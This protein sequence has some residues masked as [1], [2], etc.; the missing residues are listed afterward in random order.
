[1]TSQNFGKMIL[2][3]HKIIALFVCIFCVQV[4]D[5]QEVKVLT[6]ETFLTE[7]VNRNPE[8]LRADLDRQAVRLEAEIFAANLK[9]QLTG[10]ANFPNYARTFQEVVQPDGTIAF[11]SVRNNNSSVSL[12]ATQR[13]SATGGLFFLR[14]ELQRF[15]D[16]ENDKFQYNGLPFRLGFQQTIFGWNEW[17]AEKKMQP[18]RLSAAEK[19]YLY[20]TEQIRL[21]AVRIYFNLLSV[22][23]DLE[24]AEV[25][26]QNNREL[27]QIAEERYAAGKISENS[28]LQLQ[29]ESAR[30]AKNKAAAAL[31]VRL[32]SA[33]VRNYLSEPS[34]GT[35][36]RPVPP[37]DLKIREIDPDAAVNYARNHRFETDNYLLQ[38]MEAEA[39]LTR[40]QRE[41]GL[42]MNL[43]ASIGFSRSAQDIN[44]I[45]T[46][47]QNEQFLQLALSVPIL[48]WGRRKAL[49]QQRTLTADYTV[50][51]TEQARI[52]L[53]TE[54]RNSVL[55]LQTAQEQLK[56]A[57]VQREI[58]EKRFNIAKESFILGA[59]SVT[60][61]GIA[62]QERDFAQRDYILT[63]S[64]YRE[65]YHVL[66]RNTLYDFATGTKIK[67]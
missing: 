19:K 67:Q 37:E 4:I 30:A 13:L 42:N 39:E 40:T 33:A 63:L 12:S 56:L 20:D 38:I 15:D 6:L 23:Q 16:F 28:L 3:Q 32:A 66:R 29:L 65:S 18:V 34:D 53:D 64:D 51:A 7:A 2:L 52:E 1:M 43:N 8:K 31:A 21:E 36:F 35:I 61:L 11:Q 25:N 47:P 58:A 27:L 22:T 50:R 9:P 26:Q 49:V 14:T 17:K 45:Y 57:T 24:I 54:V 62:R 41:N 55:R 44:T 59:I 46:D 10:F 5:A 48:D 60:E